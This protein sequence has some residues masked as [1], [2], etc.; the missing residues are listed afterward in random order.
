MTIIFQGLAPIFVLILFGYACKVKHFPGDAFWPMAERVTYYVFFPALLFANL[1]KAPLEGLP[2]ASMAGILFGTTTLAAALLLALRVVMRTGG[3]AFT[4]VFQGGIRMNTYVGIAAAAAIFGEIGLTLSAIAMA[5]L[6]PLVN[7][8]C[9]W[10]MLRYASE[11][12]EGLL[13]VFRALFRNPLILACAAGIFVNLAHVPLPLFLLNTAE[14][15]GRVSL[16]LGLLSVG[17]GLS[18]GA[19]IRSWKELGISSAVK[20]VVY[21]GITLLAC[22]SLALES[23]ATAIAVLFTAVPTSVSSYILAR[24]M[25]GDTTLMASIITWQVLFAALTIPIFL[26]LTT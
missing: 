12:K 23:T 5:T 13:T 2:A 14:I 15:L 25:G 7:V 26:T 17:A 3:P 22:Y 9:V 1:A 4:S 8:Y 24:Q 16:P 20:L 6:I 18:F 21:P 19:S 10:V 11:R